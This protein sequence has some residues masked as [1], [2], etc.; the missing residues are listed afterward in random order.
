MSRRR[1]RVAHVVADD[2]QRDHRQHGAEQE[3]AAE[4]AG[5]PAPVLGHEQVDQQHH[6]DADREHELGRERVVVDDRATTKREDD[7]SIRSLPAEDL[8][9]FGARP[10]PSP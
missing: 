1:E 4:R 2:R 9:E 10:G 5:D 7:V 8:D 6:A 3:E